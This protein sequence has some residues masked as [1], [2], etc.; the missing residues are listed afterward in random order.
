MPLR[1]AWAITVHKSQGMSL[2]AAVIDLSRAFEYGQGYVALSRVR[3][4]VGLHLLGLNERALRV[5][6][7]SGREGRRVPRR[8]GGGTRQRLS[9]R[10]FARAGKR[11]SCRL[12]GPRRAAGRCRTGQARPRP[13]AIPGAHEVAALRERHAKAYAPWTE[14]RGERPQAPAPCGRDGGCH[15]RPARSQARSHPLPPQEARADLTGGTDHRP[16]HA[17]GRGQLRRLK[18][19]S[20]VEAGIRLLRDGISVAHTHPLGVPSVQRRIRCLTSPWRKESPSMPA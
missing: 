13:R 17:G 4:L 1:L 9:G 3:E 8:V 15:R 7:L 20:G 12:P 10:S 18:R 5:H 2:D 16:P 11:R 14:G 6:P 19:R